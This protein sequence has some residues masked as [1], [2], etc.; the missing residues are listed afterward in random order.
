MES[1]LGKEISR[2][3]SCHFSCQVFSK[4][5]RREFIFSKALAFENL[6]SRS[7]TSE[8][9]IHN[10]M[11]VKVN[12]WT[13]SRQFPI[14]SRFISSLLLLPATGILNFLHAR[15]TSPALWELCRMKLIKLLSRFP[16]REKRKKAEWVKLCFSV[17]YERISTTKASE[18]L[19]IELAGFLDNFMVCGL[20]VLRSGSKT[21]KL[22]KNF[23]ARL[24][25]G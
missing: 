1:Y 20:L 25:R 5:F 10:W 11:H 7:F 13:L 24:F 18:N 3:R 2:R 23:F 19:G 22:M 4:R 16:R 14:S 9:Y 17:E 15:Q 21:L 12:L 8:V 6:F